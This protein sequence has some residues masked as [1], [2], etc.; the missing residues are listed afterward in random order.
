MRPATRFASVAVRRAIRS[1][2]RDQTAFGRI[3]V[4]RAPA[5]TNATCFRTFHSSVGLRGITPESEDPTPKELPSEETPA[6]PTE[7][8][9]AEFHER[10]DHYLGELLQRLEEAQ[11]NDPS[12]EADYSV[13]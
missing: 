10:A 12:I 9:M 5:A 6:K 11:E 2:L 3:I 1:P 13:R 8:S 4:N 7:L